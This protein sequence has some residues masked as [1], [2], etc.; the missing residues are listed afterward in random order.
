MLN[1]NGA[2]YKKFLNAGDAEL[3]INENAQSPLVSPSAAAS[4]SRATSSVAAQPVVL[5]PASPMPTRSPAARL[6]LQQT[7]TIANAAVT[8]SRDN[9]PTQ[10]VKAS[11]SSPGLQAPRTTPSPPPLQA[12]S[13]SC[14]KEYPSSNWN[15]M[16][17]Y[18][19]GS[20]RGNGKA[21]STAGVGV[22]WGENDLRLVSTTRCQ[23][24]FSC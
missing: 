4:R 24:I 20:C 11:G 12:A 21:G 8:A 3:W 7:N 6:V 17:V 16:V 10:P 15:S 1:F 22:F 23:C 14:S 19:D 18:T 5:P 9:V 2:K 13:S